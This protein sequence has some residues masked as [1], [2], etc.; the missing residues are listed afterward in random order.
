MT[1]T[2]TRQY[3]VRG[4]GAGYWVLG[5]GRWVLGAGPGRLCMMAVISRAATA[6]VSEQISL[7]AGTAAGETHGNYWAAD[8]EQSLAWSSHPP[9]N[10]E[11][12]PKSSEP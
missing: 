11:E 3:A 7:D 8:C 5:V 9:H 10:S 2:C 12:Q 1:A 6:A 4:R